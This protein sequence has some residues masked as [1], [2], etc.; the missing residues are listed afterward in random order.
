MAEGSSLVL[1]FDRK[2]SLAI[3]LIPAGLV[4]VAVVAASSGADVAG[5]SAILWL[6]LASMFFTIASQ[7][8]TVHVD[9][10]ARRLRIIR[11]FFGRWSKTIV[12]CPFD[13]CRKLGRIE[14]ESDGHAS[15]GVYVELL[16]GRRHDI[17][18]KEKTVREA[19]RVAAQLSD[20]TG[21]PRLDARY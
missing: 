20:A 7:R 9:L 8:T 16:S 15:Y 3:W 13:Q 6:L 4:A 10:R 18:I 1:V 11:R 17:P 2:R 21:I 12:D 14:Y 19:G 5:A